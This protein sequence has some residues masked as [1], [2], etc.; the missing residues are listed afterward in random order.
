MISTWSFVLLSTTARALALYVPSTTAVN[1]G[2]PVN[3]FLMDASVVLNTNSASV[4]P[5]SAM[6]PSSI[7]EVRGTL[8]N[9]VC[10]FV[11]AATPPTLVCVT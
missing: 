9:Q 5:I 2:V 7:D 11:V 10:I 1:S 8:L 3:V 4:T 6:M